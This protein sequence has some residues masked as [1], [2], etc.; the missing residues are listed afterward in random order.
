M[1]VCTIVLCFHLPMWCKRK[2][3]GVDWKNVCLCALTLMDFHPRHWHP[4]PE[5][6]FQTEPRSGVSTSAPVLAVSAPACTN[7]VWPPLRPV[8]M[9]QNKPSTM[10]SSSVQSIDLLMDC[11]AWRFWTMRQSNGCSTSALRSSAAKEWFQQL[12]Q[13]RITFMW[14]KQIHCWCFGKYKPNPITWFELTFW[15]WIV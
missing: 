9:A 14:W 6:P 2:T 1:S 5:W 3:Q 8:S 4:P 12:A 7:G 11:M 15:N 10:L 13:K